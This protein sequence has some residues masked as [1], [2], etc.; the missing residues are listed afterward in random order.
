M[1]EKSSSC[2]VN[3]QLIAYQSDGEDGKIVK[4]VKRSKRNQ[5]E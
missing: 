3:N 4:R 2:R 1:S 5:E